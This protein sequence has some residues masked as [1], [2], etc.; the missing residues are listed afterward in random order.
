MDIQV[1]TG[2]DLL[3]DYTG[4]PSAALVRVKSE[5]YE[6]NDGW[7]GWMGRSALEQAT[8][9]LAVAEGSAVPP[10]G[11]LV[12]SPPHQHLP[13]VQADAA[14]AAA[15]QPPGW[16][17]PTNPPAVMHAFERQLTRLIERGENEEDEKGAPRGLLEAD[18]RELIGNFLEALP[19]RTQM[20][21]VLRRKTAM[22]RAR[23]DL[24]VSSVEAASAVERVKAD[25]AD[26]DNERAL[27]ERQ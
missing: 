17:K 1:R 22:D 14:P 8:R 21:G 16:T 7:T 12:G 20:F 24:L 4:K 23:F 10:P 3:C 5:M 25:A 2:D 9:M 19:N 13:F 11:V 27:G 15:H 6:G 18:V 26:V